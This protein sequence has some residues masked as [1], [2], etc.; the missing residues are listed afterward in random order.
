MPA[1]R[2]VK[3]G[4][5]VTE[6]ATETV[7]IETVNLPTAQ[8]PMGGYDGLIRV[9]NP[10]IPYTQF[11]SPKQPYPEIVEQSAHDNRGL[12]SEVYDYTGEDYDDIN[13]YLRGESTLEG[14]TETIAGID[15]WVEG[16]VIAAK[17]HLRDI[18]PLKPKMITVDVPQIYRGISGKTNSMIVKALKKGGIDNVRSEF[19]GTE[20]TDLAFQSWS[21]KEDVAS[22]YGRYSGTIL[23]DGIPTEPH[24]ILIESVERG[25]PGRYIGSAS[26]Y[27]SEY[28][29]LRPRGLTSVIDRIEIGERLKGGEVRVYVYT[30]LKRG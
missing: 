1:D 15:N 26:R 27:P 20:I 21:L 2:E 16:Q 28:E 23:L 14:L 3:R 17:I 11:K 5:T 24:V 29:V 10:I 30:H 13:K 6:S 8:E 9:D 22:T 19:V 4:A 18:E 25:T 7:P 12:P